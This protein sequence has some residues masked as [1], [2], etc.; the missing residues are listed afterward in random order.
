MDSQNRREREREFP[1]NKRQ[2]EKD[3]WIG[4]LTTDLKSGNFVFIL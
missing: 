4:L 1:Q 2:N 3:L